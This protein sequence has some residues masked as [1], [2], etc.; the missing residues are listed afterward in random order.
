[1]SNII[2]LFVQSVVFILVFMGI[3]YLLGDEGM[4]VQEALKILL[5]YLVI[6]WIVERLF[7]WKKKVGANDG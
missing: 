7:R 5:I 4:S 2:R 1:M 3:G 6:T